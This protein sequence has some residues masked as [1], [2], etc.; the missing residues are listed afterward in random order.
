MEALGRRS[1]KETNQGN[2]LSRRKIKQQ[3]D[4]WKFVSLAPAHHPAFEAVR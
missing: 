1:V 3:L 2:A 4:L